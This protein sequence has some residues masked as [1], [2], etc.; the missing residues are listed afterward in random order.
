MWIRCVRV[1]TSCPD[2]PPEFRFC[3]DGRS[4]DLRVI[5]LPTF[6]AFRPVV[7][8]H[9]S[10]LTVAGAVAALVR[11]GIA[12]LNRTVFPFHPAP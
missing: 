7:F 11:S 10:P 2:T 6:P 1:L 12:G 9:R 3:F 8:W 5:A 4:P